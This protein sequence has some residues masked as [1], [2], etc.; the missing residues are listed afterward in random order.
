MRLNS[1]VRRLFIEHDLASQGSAARGSAT[2]EFAMVLP[3]MALLL[4]F[5][6]VATQYGV[7]MVRA[8][9][10]AS[11]SARVAITDSN[12]MAREAALTIVGDGASV[13]I[14]RDG[15]WIRVTVEDT[16]P[17]DLVVRASAVTRAQD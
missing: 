15:E 17:W 4:G 7:A 5:I 8:Q 13:D 14:V 10:A 9:D 6:G 2:V 3:A 16:G 11:A 1:R 12:G